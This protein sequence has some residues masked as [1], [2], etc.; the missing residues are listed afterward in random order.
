MI[1]HTHFLLHLYSI[2][3]FLYYLSLINPNPNSKETKL[4]K[5][6][7]KTEEDTF[8][9]R[10]TEKIRR[11][12]LDY[13]DCELLWLGCTTCVNR[14][15]PVRDFHSVRYPVCQTT[16]KRSWFVLSQWYSCFTLNSEHLVGFRRDS[17]CAYS[18]TDVRV[19]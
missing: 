12:R 11:P 7:K 19:N 6:K 1:L 3:I 10:L 2:S 4:E 9:Q 13:Q 15:Y 5:S 8:W 16:E 14:R 17:Y 18:D